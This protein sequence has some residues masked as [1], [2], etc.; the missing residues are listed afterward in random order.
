MKLNMSTK[1]SLYGDSSPREF[2][3]LNCIILM[4]KERV[5]LAMHARSLQYDG[6]IRG[7]KAGSREVSKEAT[8]L[9]MEK[10]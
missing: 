6:C 8:E 3:F 10:W 2:G 5:G 9:F 7:R 4:W 1:A